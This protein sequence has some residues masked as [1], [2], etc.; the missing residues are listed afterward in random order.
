[1]EIKGVGAFTAS[2]K[3][4]GKPQLPAAAG[5]P[6]LKESVSVQ[7]PAAGASAGRPRVRAKDLL[8]DDEQR[9]LES[10]FPGAT[11]GA[12]AVETYAGQGRPGAVLPGTLVDRKG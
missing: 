2:V 6:A 3:P 9:F 11:D 4:A 8:S 5:S 12:G 1:M 7:T 10:L